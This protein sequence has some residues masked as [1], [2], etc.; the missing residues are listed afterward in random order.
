MHDAPSMVQDRT[1]R[2]V[3]SHHLKKRTKMGIS[4]KVYCNDNKQWAKEYAVEKR[5]VYVY[6][7]PGLRIGNKVLAHEYSN[8]LI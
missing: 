1:T 5:T 6:S 2:W 4:E 8:L 7:F 3:R